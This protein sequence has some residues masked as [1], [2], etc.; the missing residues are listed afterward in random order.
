MIKRTLFVHGSCDCYI[1]SEYDGKGGNTVATMPSVQPMEIPNCNFAAKLPMRSFHKWG[2]LQNVPFVY[3]ETV[4]KK[5]GKKYHLVHHSCSCNLE[6]EYDV[7]E[8]DVVATLLMDKP[9][10]PAPTLQLLCKAGT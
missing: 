3:R 2:Q 1:K 4:K 8:V 6:S 10:A 9:P 7:N 5:Y